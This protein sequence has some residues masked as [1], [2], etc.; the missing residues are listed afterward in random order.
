MKSNDIVEN[1]YF[2]NSDKYYDN[3]IID[4]DDINARTVTAHNGENT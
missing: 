4:H 2:P 1:I 3:K